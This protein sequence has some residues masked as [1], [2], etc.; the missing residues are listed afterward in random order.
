M[1]IRENISLRQYNTFGIDVRARYF[2]SF[3]GIDLLAEW[4]ERKPRVKK[5]ILGGGSNMLFTKNVD[6][7]VLKNEI[8]GIEEIKEDDTYV[9]VRAGA[10]ENWHRFVQYCIQRNWA[11]LE[12]LSLIP[13]NVGAAPMQNIGA[14]G[15]E[16]QEVFNSLSAYHLHDKKVHNFTAGDC[17]FGYRESVFKKRY[18]DQ[19]IILNV[20]FRLRKHPVF[21]TSYGAIRE[22]LE[23]MQVKAL[24]IR[25]I[26]QAVI[27]IRSSKL[28]D[29]AVI[30]NA[31]SFFKN[32]EIPL[33]QF[34]ALRKTYPAIP[35]YPARQYPAPGKDDHDFVK[36]AAGWLIEQCG[37]KGFRRGDAGVHANQSLVL[38]NYGKATGKDIYHLSGEIL[39]SVHKK[40]GIVLEREVNIV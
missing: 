1:Q 19:F 32:P 28:P 2:S 25:A 8:M 38:V 24:S 18:K 36:L 23:K 35:H 3:A 26:S 12:N 4:I 30:G 31:G 6:G 11:G 15:V 14:Y 20:T 39:R 16:L 5:I 7:I 22:E 40:F 37:W 13:G 17:A 27:N 21:H 34:E 9:Y 29:P 33:K 10:G